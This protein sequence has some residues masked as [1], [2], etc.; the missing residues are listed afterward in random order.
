LKSFNE[1]IKYALS[2]QELTG[3]YVVDFVAMIF[4]MPN[5]LFPAMALIYGGKTLGWLY[6]ATAIGAFFV[7]IFSAWTRKI[8]RHGAAVALAAMMW[9]FAILCVGLSNTFLWTML[10]LGLA[11]AADC[12]SGIFRTTIW[13]ETIPDKLRGRMA[14]LEMVSYMSGPL[15]GNAQIGILA[16]MTSMQI[17]IIT[18]GTLCLAAVIICSLILPAFWKYRPQ[19]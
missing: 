17:A 5:A 3:T 10:F 15:L 9:G 18:G 4:A 6:A 1:A 8:K 19:S 11:G 7:T 12:V 13:N 14:S 2:R 16:S